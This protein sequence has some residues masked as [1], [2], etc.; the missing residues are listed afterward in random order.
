MD[1]EVW[2]KPISYFLEKTELLS[3]TN[4]YK[5]LL[6]SL[7]ASNEISEFNSY[8][9]EVLFAHDFEAKQQELVYEVKQLPNEKSSV[10]FLYKFNEL[11]IYFELRLIQQQNWITKSIAAQLSIENEY[12]IELSSGDGLNEAIR[13]QN[14]ILSKC[15]KPDG[16]PIKFFEIEAG[17]LNFIV[18]NVSEL[19]L[20]Y[21]SKEDCLCAMKGD[22]NVPLL[23]RTGILGM[24]QDLHEN[25]K[26]NMRDY[27]D[28][29]KYFRETIHGIIFVRYLKDSGSFDRIYLDWE[30]EYFSIF[31][32][33]ILPQETANL[34]DAKLSSLLKNWSN[35]K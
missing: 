10:D 20:G 1:T 29:F 25:C 21:I 23:H 19:H 22:G 17:T 31:N 7:F 18:V 34:I 15:Q 32:R 6:K 12:T 4:R 24:W 5:G 2:A 26:K 13:L 9:F 14:L 3:E 11:N 27:Y 33:T 8:V 30:L 16:T 35:E 28:N